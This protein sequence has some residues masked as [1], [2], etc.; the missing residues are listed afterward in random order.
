MREYFESITDVCPF[1]L[2][3][4]DAGRIPVLKYNPELVESMYHELEHYD[5]I[6]FKVHTSICRQVLS[7][8]ADELSDTYP[9]AEWFWSHPA[10]GHKSTVVPVLLMQNRENLAKARK[11]LKLGYG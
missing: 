11:T 3:S 7:T 4:F 9:D 1:S 10:D 2:E 6:L 5:A 8:T